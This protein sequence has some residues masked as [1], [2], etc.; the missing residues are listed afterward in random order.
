MQF[1]PPQDMAEATRL[2]REGQLTDATALLQRLLRGEAAAATPSD[3][4]PAGQRRP[5]IIDVEPEAAERPRPAADAGEGRAP[6]GSGGRT[7]AAGGPAPAPQMPDALRDFVE[8]MKGGVGMPQGL[9]AQALRKPAQARVP[10]P[11]GARF[12]ARSFSGQAGSRAY[13]L[14]I[15]ST[16][17]G[18]PAP[19]VV[20]LHGCTQSPD[21]FA[22]GTKMNALAEEHGFLVAYPG[23]PPSANAQKC[24]NWFNPADQRRGAGEPSLIAGITRQ[25]MRDHAVDPRR[26]YVAGLS[27]G[28]AK[29]AIMGMAYPDLYAAVGVHSGLACGAA[30]DVQS[31]FAAMRGGGSGGAC[32]PDPAAGE[33]RPVPAIV[34]HADRDGTVHP[35]NADQ[36]AAQFGAPGL[37]RQAPQRG[38]VAG[39]RPYTR[40]LH[41]DADGRVLLEQW[42]VHGGGHAWSGGSPDGSYTDPLG[43]DASREMLRFFLDHPRAG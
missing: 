30:S 18:Q 2:V 35:R 11:E 34:F 40:T 4:A 42:T 33:R 27:A 9:D 43:P 32:R 3:S 25:V 23:Q 37:R 12:V 31:A 19:L 36:V 7:A 26:V 13:K 16:H 20:M 17:R 39:G 6:G 41:A 38:Q 15:P 28:G 29:A 22:A 24:W 10:V 21:D 5:R 14:Y 1:L 8:R